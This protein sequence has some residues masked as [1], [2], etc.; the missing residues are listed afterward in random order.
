M[1]YFLNLI[2]I[3]LILIIISFLIIISSFIYYGRDLPDFN[4]LKSYE[5]P[6]VSKIFASDGNF[7]EEYSKEN[8]VYTSFYSHTGFDLRG[9][10]RA[11]LKNMLNIFQNKRPQGASTITQQVAKNILLS[12]EVSISRKIK[13]IILSMRIEKEMSKEKIMELYLNEI[14][15]G[16]RSYGIT[17]ASIN[18]LSVT[19]SSYCSCTL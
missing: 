10:F 5:P 9:I 7:L 18:Y 6:V 3:L 17:A 15:L 8:R 19:S 16:N 13:E 2:N 4:V 1:K 14:Y 12:N 11:F